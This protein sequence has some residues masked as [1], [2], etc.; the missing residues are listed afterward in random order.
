M[1]EKKKKRKKGKFL[2]LPHT[3]SIRNSGLNSLPGD[4]DAC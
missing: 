4:S 2:A 1:K 3:Y